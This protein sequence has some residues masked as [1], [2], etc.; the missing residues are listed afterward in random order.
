MARRKLKVS[1]IIC[2]V[3]T[4]DQFD[5]SPEI[6][7]PDH[8]NSK[9][10][11]TLISREHQDLEAIKE[12]ACKRIVSALGEETLPPGA[13]TEIDFVV[14][15]LIRKVHHWGQAFN[16]NAERVKASFEFSGT[17]DQVLEQDERIHSA[18]EQLRAEMGKDNACRKVARMKLKGQSVWKSTRKNRHGA[19][20]ALGFEGVKRA[21]QRHSKRLSACDAG[22]TSKPL[23]VLVDEG[24]EPINVCPGWLS[25]KIELPPEPKPRRASKRPK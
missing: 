5:K 17:P 12:D 18:V 20:A 23:S 2:Q 11:N 9:D 21:H 6:R 13:V 14:Q 10:L 19:F 24:F 16:H 7:V 22:I 3:S 1:Q 15:E 25:F 4:T 8:T